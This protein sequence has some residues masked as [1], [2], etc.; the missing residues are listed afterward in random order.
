R[1][2][3]PCPAA[4]AGPARCAGRGLRPAARQL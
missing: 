3:A 1:A 2:S 4:P